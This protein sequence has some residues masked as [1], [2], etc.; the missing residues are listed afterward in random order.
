M[1]SL[2]IFNWQKFQFPN[3]YQVFEPVAIGKK[4][5]SSQNSL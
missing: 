2:I 3:L 1:F 4:G 5:G